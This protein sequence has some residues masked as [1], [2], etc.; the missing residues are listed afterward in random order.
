[1]ST[2]R[3]DNRQFDLSISEAPIQL[4]VLA[5]LEGEGIDPDEVWIHFVSEAEI[6]LLHEKHFDDPTPTDCISFPIDDEVL[7]EVVVCPKVAIDY[8]ARQGESAYGELA[9]Y[10]VHGVLHLI[11]YEDTTLA[12]AAKMRVAEERYRAARTVCALSLGES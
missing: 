12:K 10:V 1:V 11:G 5:V 4:L 3:I 6:S 9:L 7:G 8:A 2:V